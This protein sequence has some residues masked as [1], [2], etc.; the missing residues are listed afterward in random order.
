MVKF[1]L[2]TGGKVALYTNQ[3]RVYIPDKFAT[4]KSL[5]GRLTCPGCQYE[6]VFGSDSKYFPCS[7][8]LRCPACR[9]YL[10]YNQN[11]Y[12]IRMAKDKDDLEVRIIKAHIYPNTG[13]EY[14]VV[15]G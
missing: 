4:I 13:V 15:D 14:E 11:D 10:V 1:R 7:H 3:Y 9:F 12:T 6:F 2:A 8:T 5:S